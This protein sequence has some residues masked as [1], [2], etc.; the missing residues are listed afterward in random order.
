MIRDTIDQ[1]E[2]SVKQAPALKDDAK[3]E[4]LGLLSR[5]KSEVDAL[6]KTNADQAT[7]IA[8][9]AAVSTHE[10]TRAKPDREL[11]EISL[12][13]LSHS[14]SDFEESHPGLVQ[15]VNSISNT[16]SNLGI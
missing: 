12:G 7:S 3:S 15:V 9:F 10:A 14:V 6:S 11:L 4:L 2:S 5:L 8:G 13:G 16:L 1:L